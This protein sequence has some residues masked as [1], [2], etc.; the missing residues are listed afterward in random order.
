MGCTAMCIFPYGSDRERPSAEVMTAEH[1]SLFLTAD[2]DLR[3][4]L[5][6]HVRR[7]SIPC[8]ALCSKRVPADDSCFSVYLA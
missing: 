3:M 8:I 6:Y 7:Y 5:C 4:Y 2:K 1:S